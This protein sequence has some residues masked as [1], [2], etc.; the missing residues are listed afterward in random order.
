MSWQ[1]TASTLRTPVAT[2]TVRGGGVEV[3]QDA[4]LIPTEGTCPNQPGRRFW[5]AEYQTSTTPAL[6]ALVVRVLAS[7]TGRADR[8]TS[9][10]TVQASPKTARSLRT[11]VGSGCSRSDVRPAASVPRWT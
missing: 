3:G 11:R 7:L 5:V 2:A 4:W 10:P 6:S 8:C 9:T 1:A